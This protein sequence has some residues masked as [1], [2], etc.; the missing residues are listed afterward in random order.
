MRNENKAFT[1]RVI[2]SL[3]DRP[4]DPDKMFV[5][6]RTHYLMQVGRMFFDD[7]LGL[8]WVRPT[9]GPAQVAAWMPMLDPGPKAAAAGGS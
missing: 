9:T 6:V 8:F 2:R 4:S 1:D 7:E 3:Q 5:E